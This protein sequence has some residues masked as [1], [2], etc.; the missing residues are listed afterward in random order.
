MQTILSDDELRILFQQDP[1]TKGDGGFQNFLVSL[2]IKIDK[3]T[4][5]LNL[6]DDDLE[7]IPRYAFDY[8]NG[9]WQA[10]LLG[11]FG[12]VLGSRLGR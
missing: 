2:Q 8:S 5:T 6:T 7:K 10:R 4:K 9:G 12:R 11:I 3:K 1:K